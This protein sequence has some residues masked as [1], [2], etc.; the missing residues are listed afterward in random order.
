ME[1]S[2]SVGALHFGVDHWLVETQFVWNRLDG[3][4]QD[5]LETSTVQE[6][7]QEVSWL[8]KVFAVLLELRLPSLFR[9]II[10]LL[11]L[12]IIIIIPIIIIPTKQQQQ[13]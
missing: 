3:V 11:L 4:L 6:D 2:G 13:Q 1:C 10:P 9:L 8:V 12:L 7:R 5:L